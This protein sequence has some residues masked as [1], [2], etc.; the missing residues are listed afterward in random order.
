M[1]HPIQEL[2][3]Q[4]LSN[5]EKALQIKPDYRPPFASR[6]LTYEKLGKIDL[7][8]T[9]YLRVINSQNPK[10]DGLEREA[11]ETA[12]SRLAALDSGVAPPTIPAAPSSFTKRT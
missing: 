2:P 9:E 12:K 3:R 7:A 5:Y 8:H 1:I 10:V 11:L 4:T 6:G